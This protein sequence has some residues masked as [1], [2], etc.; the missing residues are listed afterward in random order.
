MEKYCL[1][2]V[3]PRVTTKKVTPRYNQNSVDTLKWS[4]KNTPIIEKKARKGKQRNKK[5]R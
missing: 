4:P 5:Q 1:Y 3:I 2:V